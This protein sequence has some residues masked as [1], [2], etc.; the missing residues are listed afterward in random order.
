VPLLIC[1]LYGHE[2]NKAFLVPDSCRETE[3]NGNSIN[4]DVTDDTIENN[5]NDACF[6]Y[7][8]TIWTF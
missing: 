7:F 1:I 8:Q 2:P 5:S 6:N 4:S 3:R